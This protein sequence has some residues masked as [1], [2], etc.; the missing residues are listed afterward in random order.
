MA[1]ISL[2]LLKQLRAETHAPMHDC[3]HALEEANGDIEEAKEILKK[4]G[5]VKAAKKLDRDATEGIVKFVYKNGT[6]YGIRVACETDFVAKNSV[7]LDLVDQIL[8]S[9]EA[10]GHEVPN[11]ESVPE[12]V[13]T[14]WQHIFDEKNTVLGENVRIIEVLVKK[15]PATVYNHNGNRI[16][17]VVYHD[18]SEN[19]DQHVKGAALQVAAMDPQYF[20]VDEVPQHHLDKMKADFIEQLKESGKSGD[21]LEKIVDGKIAKALQEVTLLEQPS[22]MDDSKK[23]KDTLNGVKVSGFVRWSI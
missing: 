6:V 20:S 9:V 7:F 3:K 12:D 13:K 18:G 10:Y 19:A 5:I 11:L 15:A 1:N 16:A 4:K 22:I 2:D 14:K 17:T 21:M 8:A 23:V